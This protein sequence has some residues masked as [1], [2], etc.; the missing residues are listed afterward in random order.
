MDIYNKWSMKDSLTNDLSE[1]LLCAW[2][3][4]VQ[5]LSQR[6]LRSKKEQDEAACRDSDTQ[7]STGCNS[8]GNTEEAMTHSSWRS[9]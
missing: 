7:P 2:I 1:N 4:T 5:L 8:N 3:D 9:R 6:K